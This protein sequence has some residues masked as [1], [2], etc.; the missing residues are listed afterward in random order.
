[1]TRLS[2]IFATMMFLIAATAFGQAARAPTRA[3][4]ERARATLSREPSAI[5]T[6]REG[7][8]FHRLHPE[9]IEA[10]RSA[11]RARAAAPLLAAGYRF[12][13]TDSGRSLEQTMF[14]PFNQSE[15]SRS[16][17]H[18][19]SIGGVWDLR[20]AVFNAAEI[21]AYG[22]V[23]SQHEILMEISHTYYMRRGQQYRLLLQPPEDEMARLTIEL[24][25]EEYTAQ[26][27]LMT[28]GWFT[29]NMR[30]Q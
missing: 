30:S 13:F 21:Q 23:G 1:M 18:S 19:A 25:I 14:Q 28:G 7:L 6:I 12:D 15:S 2:A 8:R 10:L 5:L 3:D 27:D 17:F 9:A 22:L 20:E 16:G 11:A 29:E 24:R 26:L 4:V